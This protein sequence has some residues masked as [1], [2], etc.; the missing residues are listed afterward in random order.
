MTNESDIVIIQHEGKDDE[1]WGE[2]YPPIEHT[3]EVKVL[4]A[5]GNKPAKRITYTLLLT[6]KFNLKRPIG[7]EIYVEPDG[8]VSCEEMELEDIEYAYHIKVEVPSSA[9]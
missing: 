2:D 6:D 3:A 7:I 8:K 4:G 9:G 1:T 5:N